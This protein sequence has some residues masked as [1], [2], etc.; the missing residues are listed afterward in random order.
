[1]HFKKSLKIKKEIININRSVLEE[2]VDLGL[3]F[4]K[5]VSLE[6]K[7]YKVLEDSP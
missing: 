7:V 4:P 3:F 6:K 1:M 2:P 5:K